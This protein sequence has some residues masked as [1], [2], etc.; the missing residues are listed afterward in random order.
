MSEIY[1]KSA[2]WHRLNM[3]ILHQTCVLRHSCL[4]WNVHITKT[5]LYNFDPFKLH[6][7]IVKRVYRGIHYLNFF[8]LKI[9]NFSVINFSVYL[10]RHVFVMNTMNVQRRKTERV[11]LKYFFPL[12]WSAPVACIPCLAGTSVRVYLISTCATILAWIRDA[13]INIWKI[14]KEIAR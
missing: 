3:V 2:H 1:L 5:R 10:N 4:I 14:Q 13:F 11:G 7:Y 6:F 8:C 9:F 12:T